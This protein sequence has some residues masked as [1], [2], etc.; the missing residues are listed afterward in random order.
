[1]RTPDV[2]VSY[3]RQFSHLRVWRLS[4]TKRFHLSVAWVGSEQDH[5]KFNISLL[6]RR[7]CQITTV[8][9]GDRIKHTCN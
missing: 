8:Y 5:L 1:M 2:V 9:E 6:R 4:L 7:I 3:L